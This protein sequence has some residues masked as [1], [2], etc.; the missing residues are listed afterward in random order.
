MLQINDLKVP[1]KPKLKCFG[2]TYGGAKLVDM[3]PL[4]IRETKNPKYISSKYV[5][6]LDME[7]IP[8]YESNSLFG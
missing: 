6:R 5:N 2:F 7:N 8:S 3:L 1:E 4:Q